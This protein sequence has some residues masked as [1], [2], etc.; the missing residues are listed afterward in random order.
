M[1]KPQKPTTQPKLYIPVPVQQS[2]NGRVAVLSLKSQCFVKMILKLSFQSRISTE[3]YFFFFLFTFPRK[4]GWK[5]NKPM[6]LTAFSLFGVV[7][8]RNF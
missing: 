3:C 2:A 5:P 4:E 1:A 8:V 6:S 7:A